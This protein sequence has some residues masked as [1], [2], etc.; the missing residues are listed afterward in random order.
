MNVSK[1]QSCLR[2]WKKKNLEDLRKPQIFFTT[3]QQTAF[4]FGKNAAVLKKKLINEKR[5]DREFFT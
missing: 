4:F 5:D 2:N 3:S 1:D